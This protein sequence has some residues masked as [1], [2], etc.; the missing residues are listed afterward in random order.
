[1]SS[2]FFNLIKRIGCPIGMRLGTFRQ[3]QPRTPDLPDHSTSD[4]L[5]CDNPLRIALVTP[6]LNQGRFLD[7]AI[8]GV[9]GQGV[10]GLR[11]AVVDGGSND[12][13]P[14]HIQ[15]HA[16]D[17]HW[18]CSEGDDGQS[19][20]IN[21]GFAN[22]L[23]TCA[24]RGEPEF[25][26]MD[27]MGWLNADDRLLPGALDAVVRFFE[28]Y[29]KVDVVYGHRIV[30]DENGMEVGRWVTPVHHPRSTH[31]GH[32][33][34]QETMFWRRRVWEAAGGQVDESLHFAMDWDL[35]I[36]LEQAAMDA[37]HR[38]ERIDRFLGGFTTHSAQKSVA[39]KEQIGR[40]EFATIRDRYCGR[41]WT[42]LRRRLQTYWLLTRSIGSWWRWRLSG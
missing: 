27:L 35:F 23:G 42:T 2:L 32:Y 39:S 26:P 40:A 5:A 10:D 7:E 1:M 38:V 17:L 21:V 28:K 29:P 34:P 13:S 11:Y 36:R 41:G 3:Y 14:A 22:L 19:H 12:E 37:G 25:G 18:W 6:C 8:K 16:D 9:L 24:D 4:T 31:W 20:A 30:L 15:N 33:V